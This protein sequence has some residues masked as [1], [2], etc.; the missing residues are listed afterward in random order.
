[1]TNCQLGNI[2]V[3]DN[4]DYE[5]TI[6]YFTTWGNQVWSVKNENAQDLSKLR[7]SSVRANN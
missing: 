5:V 3:S 7:G 1:M 2:L 6:R 4:V